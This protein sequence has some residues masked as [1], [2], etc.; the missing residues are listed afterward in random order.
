MYDIFV[1]LIGRIKLFF[2]VTS[3]LK[4]TNK[5]I[6]L[7]LLCSF[8]QTDVRSFVRSFSY[9]SYLRSVFSLQLM[10]IL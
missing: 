3:F 4:I 10:D 2:P 8:L 1:Y 7:Q 5:E 9:F 6:V